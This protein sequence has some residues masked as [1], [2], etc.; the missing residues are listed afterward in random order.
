MSVLGELNRRKMFQVAVVYMV[1]AWLIMQ[2]VDV[3]H[4]PLRLPEWFPTVI[5]V[6]LA[7]GF[8]IA[9]IIS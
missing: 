3:I 2:I 4:T 5:I 1:V 6:F 7:I 9:M 8:P